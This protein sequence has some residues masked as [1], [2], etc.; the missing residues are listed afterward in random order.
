VR[1]FL[2]DD[3]PEY[4]KL[5]RLALERSGHEVVGEASDGQAAIETAT[6][7]DPDVVLLDL[8]MP[9]VN[10]LQALPELRRRLPG[11]KVFVLTTSQA[12]HERRLALEAGAHGFIVKPERVF[13]L[14]DVLRDAMAHSS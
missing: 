3:N 9:N 13:T 5:A 8:N 14:S 6:A 11:T 1:L 7:V 12:P 2:C 4:R 10:G